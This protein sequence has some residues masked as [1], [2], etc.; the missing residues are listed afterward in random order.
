[1]S[2]IVDPGIWGNMLAGFQ[3][4]VPMGQ[5]NYW[6]GRQMESEADARKR[7]EVMQILSMMQNQNAQGTTS[8]TAVNDFINQHAATIP[9]LQGMQL[10]G[11]SQGEMRQNIVSAKPTP[12]SVLGP[13]GLQIP[14]PKPQ[15]FSREQ[16]EF[17]GLTD[18]TTRR[19]QDQ[20]ADT[21]ARA[22][23]LQ[24][25]LLEAQG[26]VADADSS[27][28]GLAIKRF[29]EL[30]KPFS[31]MAAAVAQE[32]LTR[33]GGPSRIT[34]EAI[35]GGKTKQGMAVPGLAD[36]A[37][38]EL[39]SSGMLKQFGTLTTE[40]KSV[41]K[42]MIAAN[43]NQEYL[44][45]Y[46]AQ[47]QRIGA[48]QRYQTGAATQ[49]DKLH[50]NILAQSNQIN[51]RIKELRDQNPQLFGMFGPMYM[52]QFGKTNPEI[53]ASMQS[54]LA[55][56]RALEARQQRL[57]HL[58]AKATLQQE[59]SPEDVGALTGGASANQP[60]QVAAPQAA[61]PAGDTIYQ[62]AKS[63]LETLPRATRKAYINALPDPTAKSRLLK[64]YGFEEK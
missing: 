44:N 45:W 46:N 57:T 60:A 54:K 34:P 4:G 31:L 27:P 7:S 25:P 49:W 9:G 24:I 48:S 51:A 12:S 47:T 11:P 38:Q 62:M 36:R 1:M 18:P 33:V 14:V 13:M 20:L 10:Q 15:Q 22:A 59:F 29:G 39:E 63:V 43:I 64:E 6:R 3:Q 2:Y 21:Q 58:A 17:A 16:Y 42:G 8:H 56:L 28:E 50:D 40:Q 55:E 35:S 32:A 61:P 23:G 41:L 53:A 19:R 37:F 52:E 5:E 30:E 26:R